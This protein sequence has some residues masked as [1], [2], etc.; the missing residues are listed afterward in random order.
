MKA[1]RAELDA[2]RAKI[3]ER[4]PWMLYALGGRA[5]DGSWDWGCRAMNVLGQVRCDLKPPSMAKS[6]TPS[7]PTADPTLFAPRTLNKKLHA[8]C[9]QQTARTPATDLPFW[10]KE[11][12]GSEAWW[13]RGTATTGAGG[14]ARPARTRA[15]S[16]DYEGL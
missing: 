9:A 12:F 13:A 4:A 1:T 6:A 15:G 16:A 8:V 11:Q 2:Y 3:G 10:Q 14:R 5:D 7:R